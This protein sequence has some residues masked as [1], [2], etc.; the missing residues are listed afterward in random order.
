MNHRTRRLGILLPIPSTGPSSGKTGN[1]KISGPVLKPAITGINQAASYCHPLGIPLAV[2][3]DGLCWIVF[4]PW[5]PQA[6]YTEKQAIVFPTISAVLE[7]FA[8]FYELLSKEASRKS[9]FMVLFDRIHE[10]RLIVDRPLRSAMST[11]ENGIVQKSALAFDLEGVFSGFFAN[12]TGEDDPEMIL[13]CFVETKESRFA[14]FS[15]DRITKNVLGNIAPAD[16][17][18]AEGLKAIVRDAVSGEPGQTVFIVGPSGAG[19]STFLDRFFKKTLTEDV[20][21][22]CVVIGIDLLD[23]G[24]DTNVALSWIT[25]RA[26]NSLETQLFENGFPEWQ[27]LQG[28][29]YSEYSKRSRGVDAFLYQRSKD[30]FK[31]KFSGFVALQME[32][33][34]E[35]YL[36]RL[37]ND[38]VKNRK[39]L[40]VFILDNTDEF[41]LD[42]KIAVFQH[43]QSFRR[44]V[45]HCMLLFPATDRSAWTFSKTDIFNIYSSRSFFLPTPPPRE[46]FRKRVDYLKLKADSEGDQ[47][48]VREYFLDR[49][50]RVT[51][52]NLG[53]FAQVIE[54]VFV[55][56][57]WA[58]K[59]VGQLSNYNMRKALGLAKRVVTSSVF[60]IDDLVQSYL[61]GQE[62]SPTQ[63]RFLNALLKGDLEFFKADDEPLIFPVF[64]VDSRVKQ[65]PLIHL[66]ILDFLYGLHEAS[67]NENDRYISARSLSSFFV[68]MSI[69]EVAVQRSLDALLWAGLIEPYD[70]SKRSYSDDQQ[71]AIAQSGINHLGLAMYN[72]IYFVQMALTTRVSSPDVADEIR[73]VYKTK[74]P[75]EA[76]FEEICAKFAKFLIEEDRKYCSVPVTDEYARQAEVVDDFRDRWIDGHRAQSSDGN[77]PS[78]LASIRGTVESYD[79][80][81]GFGFVEIPS[82]RDSAFLHSTVLDRDDVQD[83]SSGDDLTCDVARNAKGW[84]VTRVHDVRHPNGALSTAYVVKLFHDRAYGF[85]H[86][87]ELGVD[88]FFRFSQLSLRQKDEIYEGMKLQGE[89]RTDRQGRSQI[90]RVAESP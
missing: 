64:Q 29:Y 2:L 71:V 43:L 31:E 56:Q 47:G 39:K 22:R 10:N 13:E 87:P 1:F 68:V 35:S 72:E 41:D 52:K 33:H 51:I 5:V 17:D 26:I 81:R 54:S 37:L 48:R 44:A 84:I 69:S 83:L 23:A 14:D 86:V 16:V 9:T 12:L 53:A 46:V 15:L 49:G 19:K 20:R 70:L 67:E 25:E 36:Q 28:L 3:T 90:I 8:Q 58:A 78:S 45:N 21:E 40:P 42:L 55:D 11:D 61:L 66:R 77:T 24:A 59:R 50:I 30:E 38:V 57:P 6:S 80:A 27:D 7:D 89:V 85:V 73:Q 60:K 74:R 62:V 82:V 76:R 18:V 63:D 75:I 65:S 79:H 4:L 32:A 88:A 34:R